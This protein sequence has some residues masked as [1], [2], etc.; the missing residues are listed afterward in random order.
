MGQITLQLLRKRAEH[1]EG[2]VST[3]EEV[4]LHQQSIE[5]IEVLGQVCPNLKILYLQNNLIGKLQNLHKLKSL[6]YLNMAINNITK[7]QNLQK[8]EALEKLDLTINFVSKAGLLTV[9]SLAS[10]DHLKELTLMGNPCADWPGYRPYVIAKLPQLE[11][12]DGQA[13]KR[14]ERIASQQV[15][16]K[17]EA[18]LREELISEGIDPDQAALVED[19]SIYDENGEIIETGTMDENGE[20][21]RPWSIATRLIEHKESERLE[22]EAEEKKKAAQDRTLDANPTSKPARREGFEEIQEGERIMQKNEGQWDFSLQEDDK[23]KNIVLEVDVGKYLD[24]SLIKV[25][26][27]P[28]YVRLLIKGR[29]LQLIL[30]C[31]VKSDAT[32]AQRS[33]ATGRLQLTMPKH[34]EKEILTDVAHIK[35]KPQLASIGTKKGPSQGFVIR[36][37]QTAVVH[38]V[39]EE[40]DEDYV[41]DL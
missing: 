38:I 8:C 35:A 3:L 22:R 36:E 1:N 19:D 41:P 9:P 37:E 28:L 23:G 13:I 14:S 33:N 18:Q 10:N 31:E 5:K 17:L 34:N 11:K 20:M 26:V 2:M 30:P 4:A 32:I 39:A 40:V 25:D 15:I 16:D 29:L 21:K 12:L 24:T 27:Q 6:Q 7:I